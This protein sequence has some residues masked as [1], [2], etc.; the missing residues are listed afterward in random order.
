MIKIDIKKFFPSVPQHKVM[1][2]FRDHLQCAG[3]VAGLLANLICYEARLATGSAASPIISY[4]SYKPMFDEIEAFALSQGLRMTGYVDDITLTGPTAN[5]GALHQ[6]RLIIMRCG[7]KAHKAKYCAPNKPKLITGVMVDAQ[8]LALPFARWKRIK[9]DM[10]ELRR[11]LTNDNR[12]EV[13]QRLVSRLYE[14][15]QIEPM[16]KTMALHY[17]KELKAVRAA[18]ATRD[19]SLRAA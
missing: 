1:H 9:L 8:G 13:L 3:D 12:E 19:K 6:V 10:T 17:M 14:A 5:R 11:A 18:S 15:A 16:C 2:F 7:L 4:Y